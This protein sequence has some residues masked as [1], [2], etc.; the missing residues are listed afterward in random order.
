MIRGAYFIARQEQ[1]GQALEVVRT[2][3]SRGTGPV[4]QGPAGRQARA[5]EANRSASGQAVVKAMRTC[6]A[7][8]VMHAPILIRPSRSVVNA[9]VASGCG[10][11]M[12]SRTHNS[13]Q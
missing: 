12:A 2:R 3:Q 4:C 5:R 6:L 9:A 8:S 11:G 10:P 1:T 7:V 13:S